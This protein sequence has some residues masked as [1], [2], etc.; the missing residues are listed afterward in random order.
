LPASSSQLDSPRA[1]G[2]GDKV[3]ELARDN[4]L[5]RR[6][7]ADFRFSVSSAGAG[8]LATGELVVAY[9]PLVA[10]SAA[11]PHVSRRACGGGY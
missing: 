11:C 6:S 7:G 3:S 10:R 1:L 9:F 2:T 8:S 5:V 4:A